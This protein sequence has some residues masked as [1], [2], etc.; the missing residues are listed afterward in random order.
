MA[1]WRRQSRA[2][3]EE[4]DHNNGL[5]AYECSPSSRNGQDVDSYGVDRAKPLVKQASSL[6]RLYPEWVHMPEPGKRSPR[7]FASDWAEAMT[8]TRWWVVPLLWLPVACACVANGVQELSGAIGLL[9]SGSMTWQALEY[10]MHRFV[11]HARPGT[12]LLTALHFL[13]HGCHHK[14]PM[15]P[16]RLV[17]PPA[18]AVP[19][20]VFVFGLMRAVLG[21][22]GGSSAFAG[23]VMAYVW[24]DCAHFAIH[25]GGD[26][27]L[28][29]RGLRLR[30]MRHHFS[31]PY[32]FFGVSCSAIDCFLGTD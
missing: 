32:R 27:G 30:H 2:D 6:G 23:F 9:L 17:L 4:C 13:V 20:G 3:G 21:P 19:P 25:H 10:C 5:D 18:A 1:I 15:D 16:L 26:M 29:P 8:R 31:C 22:A 12:R 28:L 7:F 24:Y 11:F 14:Q